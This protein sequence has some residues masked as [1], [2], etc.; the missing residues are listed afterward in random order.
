MSSGRDVSLESLFNKFKYRV[1]NRSFKDSKEALS[2]IR[3]LLKTDYF[4]NEP[5]CRDLC[6]L[7]FASAK[8]DE[9][10]NLYK[11]YSDALWSFFKNERGY[12]LPFPYD[13]DVENYVTKAKRAYRANN[14][15]ELA[16]ALRCL[17]NHL[18]TAR[19][20]GLYVDPEVLNM[21]KNMV[22]SSKNFGIWCYDLLYEVVNRKFIQYRTI[23]FTVL[24]C[25]IPAAFFAFVPWLIVSIFICH[26]GY[27]HICDIKERQLRK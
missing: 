15:E 2:M 24:V 12:E 23:L 26:Y 19:I 25:L 4:N 13:V 22:V 16:K 7:H 10:G 11:P 1:N 6:F 17:E 3:Q 27:H 20:Y 5:D 21:A 14:V 8:Y 9:N 18:D